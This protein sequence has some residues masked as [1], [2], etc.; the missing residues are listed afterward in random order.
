MVSLSNA[1]HHIFCFHVPA[2]VDLPQTPSKSTCPTF[3]VMDGVAVFVHLSLLTV[4]RGTLFINFKLFLSCEARY[5]NKNTQSDR[6]NTYPTWLSLRAGMKSNCFP[7]I[8]KFSTSNYLTNGEK[9]NN[10]YVQN[11]SWQPQRG[12]FP[13]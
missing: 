8:S 6:Q 2:S 4:Y 10:T 5:T 7:A 3:T 13:M 9:K 11:H 12:T 1:P